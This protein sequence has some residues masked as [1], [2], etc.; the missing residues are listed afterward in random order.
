M[1]NILIITLCLVA[2]S[3]KAQDSLMT[4]KGVKRDTTSL[5]A[6]YKAAIASNIAKASLNDSIQKLPVTG[7]NYFNKTITFFGNSITA[8]TGASIAAKR[9]TS[10]VTTNLGAVEDNR[11]ISGTVLQKGTPINPTGGSPNMI[12]NVTTIPI[13]DTTKCLLVISYGVNDMGW[14]TGDYTPANFKLAYDSVLKYA[15]N[16]KK[17]NRQ[18]ILILGTG[19]VDQTGYNLYGA[20]SGNVTPTVARHLSY[21][22]AIKETAEKWGVLYTEFYTP[23]SNNGDSSLL[24]TDGLHPNDNGHAFMANLVLQ[25]LSNDQLNPGNRTFATI[26][27]TGVITGKSDITATGNILAS[28]DQNLATSITASNL[29]SG[30]SGQAQIVAISSSGATTFG[31]FSAAKSQLLNIS[32]NDGYIYNGT[33]GNL[34]FTNAVASGNIN[35]ATGGVT[36]PQLV[37]SST[38]NITTTGTIFAS[39]DQNATTSITASNATIGT[40]SQIQIV[41]QSNAGASILGKF[42][43]TKSSLQNIVAGD[44]YIYNTSSNFSQYS[45]GN[46]NWASNSGTA[47]MTLSS[48]GL[49]A[50]Q[51]RLS[52]LN[53]APSSAADTGTLGE[54]RITAGFIYICTATNT[55][56]RTA[57][58]TW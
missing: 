23:M 55:W 14:T 26:T 6:A 53:S 41:A 10:L 11:G 21:N 33:S 8:G 5:F 28:K 30:T 46:F 17:W 34:S 54:I 58:T 1:R 36:V 25:Y 2:F 35:F 48:T 47:Q 40:A 7:I 44:G 57:L 4:S 43:T 37:I 3:V 29:T 56:V 20:L 16:T 39:K 22:A 49:S 32:G 50:I 52:A 27:S 51:Y 45:A 19:Y 15:I 12:D 42:S 18:N 31:K 9:W 13:K 24:G 38:G